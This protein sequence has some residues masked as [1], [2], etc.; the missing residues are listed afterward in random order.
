MTGIFLRNVDYLNAASLRFPVAAGRVINTRAQLLDTKKT[1]DEAA[2]DPYEFMRDAYIQ[3]RQS[4]VNNEDT[5]DEVHWNRY[6]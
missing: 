1:I 4:L 5:V 3:R 6:R 2:L